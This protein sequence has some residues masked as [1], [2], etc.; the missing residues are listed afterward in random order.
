MPPAY[1]L[2]RLGCISPLPGRSLMN[3][4]RTSLG[5]KRWTHN[6]FRKF[7]P[8]DEKWVVDLFS[9]ILFFV[10]V[11]LARFLF[12]GFR[13]TPPLRCLL[14]LCVDH[15]RRSC[16]CRL[17]LDCSWKQEKTQNSSVYTISFSPSIPDPFHRRYGIMLHTGWNNISFQFQLPN[18]PS[19]P[20]CFCLLLSY[21]KQN[22]LFI[23][24]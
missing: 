21:E 9:F 24:P 14:C 5:K 1:L 11:F 20:F 16:C 19:T 2:M 15:C 10:G 6:R 23:F 4:K 17:F 18:E 8:A 13:S 3:P 12:F 22:L 7:I